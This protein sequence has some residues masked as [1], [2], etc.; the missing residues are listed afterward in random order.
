MA[1][2]EQAAYQTGELRYILVGELTPQC[3][4]SLPGTA[5][6]LNTL[7]VALYPTGHYFEAIAT[8]EK[9]LAASRGE[10]D[11]FDLFFLAMA[12][13]ALGQVA[14]A[15]ADFASALRWRSKHPVPAQ[16]VWSQELDLF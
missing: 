7:G 1:R 5:I 3:L 6:Y 13:H 15:R 4:S 10:S 11:T 8:P 16:S 14:H 2:D 9:S 12:R